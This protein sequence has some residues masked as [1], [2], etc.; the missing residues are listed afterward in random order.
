MENKIY[1]KTC[2]NCG[3]EITSLSESQCE[4]NF[5]VHQLSCKRKGSEEIRNSGD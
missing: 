4:H 5:Q 3:K 2:E 1:T